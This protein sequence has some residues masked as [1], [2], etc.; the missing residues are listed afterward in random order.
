MVNDGRD[1][2]YYPRRL[3]EFEAGVNEFLDASFAKSAIGDTTMCGI[4]MER[5]LPKKGANTVTEDDTTMHDNMDELLH[6][7]VLLYK[8]LHGL[9]NVAFDDLLKIL[10]EA[11]PE[12]NIP[13]NFTQAKSIVRDL[14]LVYEK[15]TA[16]L[17]N[18]M[19]YW[20]TYKDADTCHIC[21]TSKWKET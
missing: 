8:M 12:V 17:N 20:D 7:R 21:N 3:P 15:I 9:S 10:K 2:M 6:D 4:F 1:W 11:I 14:G 19:L 16:C 5:Y 13:A 18:C